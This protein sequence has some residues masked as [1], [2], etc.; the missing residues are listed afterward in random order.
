MSERF[1][2]KSKAATDER[3]MAHS[4]VILERVDDTTQETLREIKKEP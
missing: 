2:I 4:G 3:L 1:D